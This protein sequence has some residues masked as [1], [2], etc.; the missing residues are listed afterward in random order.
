MGRKI[1]QM[2]RVNECEVNYNNMFIYNDDEKI[3][4][5]TTRPYELNIDINSDIRNARK[6]MLNKQDCFEIRTSGGSYNMFRNG[7]DLYVHTSIIDVIKVEEKVSLKVHGETNYKNVYTLRLQ[8][9]TEIEVES[10][11]YTRTEK[12]SDRRYREELAS[13]IS[14]CLY[15]GKSVSHYEVERLLEK[16]DITIR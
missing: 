11:Y 14:E 4:F 7:K 16:L 1:L 8:D 2:L 12:T 3:L 15:S 13:I 9:G 10:D 5:Q 6:L